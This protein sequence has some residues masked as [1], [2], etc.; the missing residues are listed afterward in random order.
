MELRF[1]EENTNITV[2]L[3]ILFFPTLNK[4]FVSKQHKILQL[5]YSY[6]KGIIKRQLFEEECC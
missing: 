5:Q 6:L 1:K 4:K 2:W 3:K